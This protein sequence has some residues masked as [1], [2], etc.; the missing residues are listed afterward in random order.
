MPRELGWALMKIPVQDRQ[1]TSWQRIPLREEG[2]CQTKSDPVAKPESSEGRC[3][4]S[5]EHR[6]TGFVSSA[7]LNTRFRT[8]E[9]SRARS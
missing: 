3:K 8:K 5:S 6:S 1:M 2:L 7:P 9:K 4:Q